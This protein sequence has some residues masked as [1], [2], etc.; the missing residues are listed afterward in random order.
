MTA[1]LLL[2][3]LFAALVPLVP[4]A[5]VTGDVALKVEEGLEDRVSAAANALLARLDAD[6]ARRRELLLRLASLP[7][8]A[9]GIEEAASTKSA[10]TADN[11][12]AIRAALAELAPREVPELVAVVTV[13]GAQMLLT[14]GG[15][16]AL[17]AA[18]LP[19]AAAALAGQLAEGIA[20][21]DGVAY[22]FWAVPVGIADG[23]LVL[24]ERLGDAAALRL[25]DIARADVTFVSGGR[26]LASSLDSDRRTTVLDAALRVGTKVATG[27]L[28]LGVPALES[29]Q[30]SFPLFAQKEA[31]RSLASEVGGGAEGVV[32]VSAER[33]LGWLARLQLLCLSLSL[34]LVGFGLLWVGIIEGPMR[35]QA[36]SVEA[37]LAR[38]R[39]EKSAR[40]GTRGFSG[41][42]VAIARELDRVADE[43]SAPPRPAREAPP[44]AP[45]EPV[46]ASET[47][48][49]SPPA[50][51][52]SLVAE[53]AG[54]PPALPPA[55]EG[56]APAA[57]VGV[58]TLPGPD[59]LP[60]PAPRLP[61]PV[62][63]ELLAAAP[64]L[65]PDDA[66]IP[67][68]PPPTHAAL[69]SAAAFTWSAPPS[70]ASP[71][72]DRREEADLPAELLARSR[73]LEAE[74]LEGVEEPDEEQFRS[75]FAEFMETKRACNEP[76]G[77]LTYDKF[78]DR[79][80]KNRE[81]LLSKYGCRSVRFQVYVRDGRA[82]VKAAPIR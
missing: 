31:Y 79:L 59:E 54:I 3:V 72:E 10:P 56:R 52:V 34:G 62:E 43:W 49:P 58:D 48:P 39:A 6:S 36:R 41:P 13:E 11:V 76:I 45:R 33:E 67:L 19:F 75:I 9:A 47:R 71:G 20:T 61:P 35:R 29:L 15:P 53:A 24:G 18:E 22:R 80:R 21:L 27:L 46:L 77:G 55:D 8:L 65:A 69:G 37:H 1:R 64:A 66:P 74:L 73:E 2:F 32:T 38:L 26:V 14:T 60:M 68:P 17:G 51:G 12:A 5:V 44:P 63:P 25:R 57:K 81:Q 16:R 78:V 4:A 70:S 28:P 30:G 50:P 42:F 7:E 82:A 23:A 40:L